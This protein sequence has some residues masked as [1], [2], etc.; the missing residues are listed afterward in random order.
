[1]NSKEI[2]GLAPIPIIMWRHT[3]E[4]NGIL[5]TVGISKL[6]SIDFQMIVPLS[7]ARMIMVVGFLNVI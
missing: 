5:G 2:N 1:M 4:F 7:I 3:P 6:K